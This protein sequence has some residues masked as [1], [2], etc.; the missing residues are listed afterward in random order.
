MTKDDIKE[1]LTVKVANAAQGSIT[2]LMQDHIDAVAGG[3]TPHNSRANHI[4]KC[5]TSR[6]TTTHDSY[7]QVTAA[8]S[9]EA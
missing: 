1:L 4:S 3:C 9:A 8:A 7:T 6:G 2:P 5:H